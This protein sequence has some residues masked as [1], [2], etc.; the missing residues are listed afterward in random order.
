MTLIGTGGWATGCGMRHDESGR[1]GA[2]QLDGG[3]SSKCSTP[4]L[5]IGT[6]DMDPLGQIGADNLG[7]PLDSV[8]AKIATLR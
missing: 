8:T 6:A 2:P 4:L 7:L 3:G 5:E 1:A